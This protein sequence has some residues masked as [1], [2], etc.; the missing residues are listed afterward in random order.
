MT[1]GDDNFLARWYRRKQAVQLGEAGRHPGG[2]AP[3]DERTGRA[4]S[5]GV[6]AAP[7]ALDKD[8]RGMPGG[9][10]AANT[11]PQRGDDIPLPRVEDLTAES[12]L[13]AFLRAGVPP[14]LKA[15]ALRRAWSLDPAIRD[16]VG[17]SEYA[18][19]FN[20]PATIPGF[21]SGPSW[22][23]STAA[24]YAQK[25]VNHSATER[26]E[27]SMQ[28]HDEQPPRPDLESV[29]LPETDPLAVSADAVHSAEAP[30]PA[31]GREGDAQLNQGLPDQVQLGPSPRHGGAMPK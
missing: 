19:D 27:H 23:A 7:E 12:D 9:A 29:R 25:I 10:S 6:G 18:Y 16:Y 1:G 15:A 28:M 13:S 22:D 24:E 31:G 26:P 17:P 11:S 30:E 14:A 21:G 2:E 4:M 3:P 20:N 5:Q 8:D